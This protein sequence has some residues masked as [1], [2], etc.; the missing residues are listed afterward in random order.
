MENKQQ[1][2]TYKSSNV[3][4]SL[5]ERISYGVADFGYAS[6]YMWVSSFMTIF[7]TDYV[8]V[9]AASVSALL[10]VVRIFDAIND[11]II[12]SI[13]DRTK[14]K[15]GRYRPWIAVGGTV[16][17][18]MIALMFAVQ[19]TWP[20]GV[21]IAWM[22]IV[23]IMVTVAATCYAMPFNALG[24]V[25]TSNDAGRVK[26]SNTRMVCSSLGSN[27]TN[28][29]A[30]TLILLLSGTNR[31]SNT[32]QGY[33]GAA[34]CSVVISLP[35]ILWSAVKS[36]ERV[37][38]PPQQME[39]KSKISLGLQMKCLLGNKYALGCMFGQFVAGFYTY[40]RYTI[41]AYYFT[42]YEGDFNLYSITGII[43]LFTGIAGSGLLGPW[44]YKVI[45]HKGRAVGTAFGLSGILSIPIFWI[46]AKGVLFWVFYAVSTALGT[47][48]FG[49]RYGCDGDNAD[50]AEYKYG[51]R[52]DGFLSAFISMMLKAGGA[53]GPAVL[54]VWLDS[55]GYVANQAQ[56]ASVLNALNMGISF[57]PAVLLLLVAL[58]FLIFYDM[59]SK[60]H[61]EIVKELECR[62]GTESK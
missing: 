44:L 48:A 62:R 32:A 19:P 13:A 2:Y 20:M 10:L 24:G 39:K 47:A 1:E 53:V 29:I 46:S 6:A 5:G 18:L 31:T 22:W 17:C 3:M 26:L 23:Y 36:K 9:P 28:L 61:A 51:I 52:V 49:L 55:L 30:A 14:S 57:I 25:I 27:F 11:P 41:M 42:Y 43:G 45:Q 7:F 60:K 33:F 8:G 35:F 16:M 58:N 56:N 54:L 50:Y 15:Y 38:P 37:Q 40:G 21:K 4:P 34:V 12:G 59:D